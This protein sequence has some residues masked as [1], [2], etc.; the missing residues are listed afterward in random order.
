MSPPPAQV[1]IDSDKLSHHVD[2]W[3]PTHRSLTAR[4]LHV[5]PIS[6]SGG[7][8]KVPSSHVLGCTHAIPALG[9]V[10]LPN[11]SSFSHISSPTPPGRLK[12]GF[13]SRARCIVEH[14]HACEMET[15]YMHCNHITAAGSVSSPG[16]FGSL[17][18][19]MHDTTSNTSNTPRD[20][21][22]GLCVGVINRLLWFV[23]I[24]T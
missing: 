13:R 7:S 14:A 10:Y 12:Q 4:W 21:F 23:Y 8:Y 15:A 18:E 16:V 17:I 20:L 24:L 22:H 1:I 11:K 5:S 6:F 3:A 2:E 19:Y 9:S